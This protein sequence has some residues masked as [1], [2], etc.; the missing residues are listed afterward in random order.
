MVNDGERCETM[1][2]HLRCTNPLCF[3]KWTLHK[4][5]SWKLEALLLE[6][7]LGDPDEHL[8]LVQA[9]QNRL[10]DLSHAVR[11]VLG[12]PVASRHRP[13]RVGS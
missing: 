7:P 8:E 1:Y 9:A 6:L 4:S 3:A 5:A 11:G 12:G 10:D 13:R 2:T